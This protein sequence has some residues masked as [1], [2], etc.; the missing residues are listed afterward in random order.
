M[1]NFVHSNVSVATT[2]DNES[3]KQVP[4]IVWATKQDLPVSQSI[5]SFK[6]VSILK[7]LIACVAGSSFG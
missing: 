7:L 6:P 2:C 5:T 3:V 1:L 4:I